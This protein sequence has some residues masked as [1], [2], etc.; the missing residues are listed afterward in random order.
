M[1]QLKN[2]LRTTMLAIFVSL[3]IMGIVGNLFF[4]TLPASD[5]AVLAAG[6]E[7]ELQ[8]DYEQQY[9]IEQQ[10]TIAEQGLSESDRL[11]TLDNQ[12]AALRMKREQSWQNLRIGLH[13]LQFEE[14]QACLRQY[15]ELQYKEQRLELL[16]Q[17]KGI[18]HCLAVL[19]T[20]Q[21]NIIVA[22]WVLAE[23]YEKIYDLVQRNTTYTAE[24]I[25]LL[26]LKPEDTQL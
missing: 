1:K 23:Q 14:K 19:E 2:V 10:K 25:I 17:A 5:D 16:L 21:A 4:G 9:A 18:H 7:Q 15:E 22:E 3:A 12:F 11:R 8:V 26:P 6:A 20:E 24:Q 13:Q